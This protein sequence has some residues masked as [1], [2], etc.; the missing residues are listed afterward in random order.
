[1]QVVALTLVLRWDDAGS[2]RLYERIKNSGEVEITRPSELEEM[3]VPSSTACTVDA[4]CSTVQG[5]CLAGFC[6]ITRDCIADIDVLTNAQAGSVH[7]GAHTRL[8]LRLPSRL[9]PLAHVHAMR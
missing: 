8:P 2:L 9:P 7:M 3:R 1:M 6:T 5:N 4:D